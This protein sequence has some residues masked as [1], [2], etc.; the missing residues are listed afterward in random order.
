MGGEIVYPEIIGALAGTSFLVIPALKNEMS[1][2]AERKALG[3]NVGYQLDWNLVIVKSLELC[4]ITF[5]IYWDDGNITVIGFP[6][7]TWEQLSQ[8]VVNN[9]LL[10]L[11]HIGL[12]GADN[13]LISPVAAQEGFLIKGLEKGI[14]SLVTKASNLPEELNVGGLMTYLCDILNNAR[15]TGSLL[16]LS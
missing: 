11:P 6:S 12:I 7:K 10:L 9:S 1:R 13:N 15:K 2:Y 8:I 16:L 5:E 3:D 4:I 14:L